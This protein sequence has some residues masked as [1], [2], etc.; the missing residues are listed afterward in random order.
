MG[1]LNDLNNLA[2]ALSFPTTNEHLIFTKGAVY[3]WLFRH[4]DVDFAGAEAH[5]TARLLQNLQHIKLNNGHYVK[6]LTVVM[7]PFKLDRG[8]H[9]IDDYFRCVGDLI[10]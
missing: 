7:G 4:I 6:Q 5:G 3:M 10:P 8:A 2:Q 1:S 9:A